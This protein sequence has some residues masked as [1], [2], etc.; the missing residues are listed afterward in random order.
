MK[1]Y[2]DTHKGMVR[3]NNEDNFIVVEKQRY[4]L[5]AVADG[6]GGHNAGEI[7]SDIAI[8]VL[9][10]YFDCES[11]EFKVPK[12][13]NE[14]INAANK[15]IRDES[16]KNE[17]YHGMGTTMTMAVIDSLENIAYIGNVGD[18]RVYLIRNNEIEQITEDHTYVHELLKQ[19]KI[20]FEEAKNHPKR[21]VITRAIG[22]EDLVQIDIFEIEL[23]PDDIL[24]LCSD[25]LIA[26]LSDNEILETIKTYGCS[27]SVDRLIKLSNDYGGIDNITII[28]IHNNLRGDNL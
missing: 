11:D 8:N 3:D 5:Y 18:S 4:N 7:A 20:T 19:G 15:I 9:K 14:S 21:N 12:F 22:S 28:I 27:E 24:L 26:H 1:V 6:M 16:D 17:V 13:I 2:F 10:E 25:G 23:L